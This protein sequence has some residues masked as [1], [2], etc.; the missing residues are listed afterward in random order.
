[1]QHAGVPA[2]SYICG[3]LC[4]ISSTGTQGT[5][6]IGVADIVVGNVF[7][8]NLSK[9]MSGREADLQSESSTGR[10]SGTTLKLTIRPE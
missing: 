1:M 10:D 3:V 2:G 6:E 5:M 9:R 8:R 7:G 4:L